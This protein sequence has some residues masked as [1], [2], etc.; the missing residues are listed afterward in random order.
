M[1]L[2][3]ICRKVVQKIPARVFFVGPFCYNSPM[4]Q[5]EKITRKD[6][7][8]KQLLTFEN[9]PD[10][11]LQVFEGWNR[12]L[13]TPDEVKEK[14]FKP[15]FTIKHPHYTTYVG[16]KVVEHKKMKNGPVTVVETETMFLNINN[17]NENIGN[18]KISFMV[19]VEKNGFIYN[20]P[21]VRMIK[22]ESNDLEGKNLKQGNATQTLIEMN[23]YVKERYGLPLYS[24][25][26][27][28]EEGENLFKKLTIKGLL[29][30]VHY[31]DNLK[32][33]MMYKFK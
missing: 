30:E 19:P 23:E 14:D 32:D 2:T 13:K 9:M 18:G 22:N 26:V 7:I 6:V 21:F 5:F 29:E 28:T 24:G 1:K 16:E 11:V 31:H 25:E 4:E 8:E 10:N 17:E 15:L 12:M 20:K 27:R 33:K 3:M